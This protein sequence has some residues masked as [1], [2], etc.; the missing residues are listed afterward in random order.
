[1][2]ILPSGAF[3]M[4]N[5]ETD[6]TDLPQAGVWPSKLQIHMKKKKVNNKKK[7]IKFMNY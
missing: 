5:E 4:K 6:H 3:T 7:K 2:K 1:V